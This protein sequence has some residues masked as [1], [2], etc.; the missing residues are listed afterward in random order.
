M[1]P[2]L[3]GLK[4]EMLM[5]GTGSGLYYRPIKNDTLDQHPSID[6]HTLNRKGC[7]SPGSSSSTYWT[8][9]KKTLY[10]IDIQVFRSVLILHIFDFENT[11]AKNVGYDVI[12]LTRTKCNYGGMR[13]WFTCSTCNRRV[14]KLLLV[15]KSLKCRHCSRLSYSSQNESH[16]DRLYR[17]IWKIRDRL[18]ADSNLH[19]PI[20]G[21]PKYMHQKTF[22][23][24]AQEESDINKLINIM[25]EK[26]LLRL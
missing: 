13:V 4:K 10:Q 7:L 14:A 21:K 22:K 18:G 24:L 17:K 3:F 8:K 12:K 5:G 25:I 1:F 15:S 9:A 19:I 26:Y 2:I 23:K 6:I 16:L 20:R 11:H